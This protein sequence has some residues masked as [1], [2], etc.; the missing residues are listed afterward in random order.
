M[1][2]RRNMHKEQKI[3]YQS[4]KSSISTKK[5]GSSVLFYLVLKNSTLEGE[6]K[7][8]DASAGNKRGGH[9]AAASA[10]GDF[11]NRLCFG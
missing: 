10:A 7:G 8:G 4:L 2:T 3:L 6:P 5:D 11:G 1:L 9:S